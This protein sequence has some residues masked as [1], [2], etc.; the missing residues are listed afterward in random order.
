MDFDLF[1]SRVLLKLRI[2]LVDEFALQRINRVIAYNARDQ[3]AGEIFQEDRFTLKNSV[4]HPYRDPCEEG[5][6][7]RSANPLAEYRSLLCPRADPAPANIT[8][9]QK[10]Q[11]DPDIRT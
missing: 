5:E 3:N 11:G 2:E 1:A 7:D 4:V 9:G 10:E 6:Y 8:R